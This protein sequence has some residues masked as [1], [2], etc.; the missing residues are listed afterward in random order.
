MDRRRD[1]DAM[2]SQGPEE[3]CQ[4]F[5][6]YWTI[7]DSRRLPIVN[8]I[9][10]HREEECPAGNRGDGRMRSQWQCHGVTSIALARV[11]I[12]SARAPRLAL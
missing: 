6:R 12:N 2:G 10:P 3:R 7:A 4:Q 8:D 11:P 9:T 1:G 5:P